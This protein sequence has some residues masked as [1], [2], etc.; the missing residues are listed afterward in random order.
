[1]RPNINNHYETPPDNA[2]HEAMGITESEYIKLSRQVN[3]VYAA[4]GARVIYGISYT[5]E[6]PVRLY[7][8][9]ENTVY[10][11]RPC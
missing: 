4:I 9:D 10:S 6:D 11:N 2:M 1:M 5:G 8:P 3:E 7:V